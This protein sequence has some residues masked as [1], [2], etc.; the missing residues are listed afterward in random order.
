[1]G[2]CTVGGQ[3]VIE[4][5]LMK[6][7]NKIAIAIRK[8]NKQITVKRQRIRSLAKKFKLLGLPFVRGPVNLIEMLFLGIKALNY[9]ANESMDEDESKISKSEFA[10]TTIIA[11]AV[12]I[13]IFIILPLYL[14][15]ITGAKGV[16]FNIIDGLIR[17]CVFLIYI[18]AI[19][20]MSDVRRLFEYHGAEHKT[21]NC[22]EAGKPLNPANVKKFSTI[23]RRCGTTF[24]LIV[25]T[26]SIIVFSLIVTD[27]FLVKMGSRIL[28]L[29]VIAGIS[30]ELLKLGSKYPKN[31]ILNALITPGLL[32]QKITTREPDKKQIEVAISAFKAVVKI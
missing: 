7:G 3:A 20:F 14:T 25:L 8:P 13:G 30:Y 4:G 16:M 31:I 9:S 15:K 22:Y 32:L 12:A 23:H 24:I 5:V 26:I 21:V 1:M 2:K 18:T 27:S 11:I 29:P 10:I 28:L 19:S 6:N 17:V